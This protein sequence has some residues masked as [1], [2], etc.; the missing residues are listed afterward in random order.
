MLAT[1]I[2]EVETA[3]GLVE[4]VTDVAE[5]VMSGFSLTF[6]YYSSNFHANLIKLFG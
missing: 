4:L 6:T 5:V 2:D 3:E 1:S